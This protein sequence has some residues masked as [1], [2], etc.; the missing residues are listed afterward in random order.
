MNYKKSLKL[1]WHQSASPKKLFHFEDGS[2]QLSQIKQSKGSIGKSQQRVSTING[3]VYPPIPLH[4]CDFVRATSQVTPLTPGDPCEPDSGLQHSRQGWKPWLLSFQ[5]DLAFVL[6]C[7]PAEQNSFR[8]T[9]SRTKWNGLLPGLMT[10]LTGAG[11]R[12]WNFSFPMSNIS[13]QERLSM[14]PD[15]WVGLLCSGDDA[16]SC[17]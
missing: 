11:L 15:I 2:G 13:S 4:I 10:L 3:D 7:A 17:T 14:A 16:H 12:H 1:G 9:S 6:F 5:G 8:W